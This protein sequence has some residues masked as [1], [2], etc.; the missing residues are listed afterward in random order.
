MTAQPAKDSLAGAGLGAGSWER[1]N[2][3]CDCG[4]PTAECG[5]CNKWK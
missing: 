4:A 5:V 1:D 3:M 2:D